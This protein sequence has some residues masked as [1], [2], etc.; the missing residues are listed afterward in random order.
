METTITLSQAIA[1]KTRLF[2][3]CVVSANKFK[4]TPTRETWLELE[5]KEKDFENLTVAIE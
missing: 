2:G 1:L 3:E 5:D 4:T